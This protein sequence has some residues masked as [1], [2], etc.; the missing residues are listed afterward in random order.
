[1]SAADVSRRGV[2]IAAAELKRRGATV[3]PWSEGRSKNF[4]RVST[5]DGRGKIVYVKTRQRGDWQTDMRKGQP[6]SPEQDPT[7]L[8]L[9][10]DLTSP[11]AEFFIAPAWW[12]ENDLYE[13]YQAYLAKHGGRRAVNPRSTHQRITID[14]VERWRDGWE[15]LGLA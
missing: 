3:E 15:L 8:W 14:R 6:R 11:T 4:L 7:R 12:I 2:E 9:F 5:R 10:V 13:D 1:M